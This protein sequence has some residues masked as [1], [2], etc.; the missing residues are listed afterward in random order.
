MSFS[1]ILN[2]QS[3]TNEFRALAERVMS[4]LTGFDRIQ[5]VSDRV[6]DYVLEK[7]T[8]NNRAL[9]EALRGII[10][11]SKKPTMA[12]M[13]GP[14]GENPF[15]GPMGQTA[16]TTSSPE[17]PS[18]VVGLVGVELPGTGFPDPPRVDA[19]LMLYSAVRFR[20]DADTPHEAIRS[21]TDYHYPA[22]EYNVCYENGVVEIERTELPSVHYIRVVIDTAF[23][24][25]PSLTEYSLKLTMPRTLF[26]EHVKSLI[27][28]HGPY[29]MTSRPVNDRLSE[30]R[31]TKRVFETTPLPNLE[32]LQLMLKDGERNS[33]LIK[34]VKR[35]EYE[36]L[37]GTL[38]GFRVTA[39][40]KPTDDY[41]SVRVLNA[42]KTKPPKSQQEKPKYRFLKRGELFKD[43]A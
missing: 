1:R 36:A 26:R 20:P 10:Q 3:Y 15:T 38:H 2:N 18:P 41:V 25:T 34:N 31:F 37:N 5:N 21:Y 14:R 27:G 22:M 35:G 23:R 33:V 39:I 19:V 32:E 6:I 11:E 42:K 28:Y 40:V 30:Y 4:V 7:E 12:T 8:N 17:T 24:E 29:H 13:V 16:M 9:M 43:T